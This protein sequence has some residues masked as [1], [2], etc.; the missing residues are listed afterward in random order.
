MKNPAIQSVDYGMIQIQKALKDLR[1][2][3]EAVF[4]EDAIQGL[5]D[6]LEQLAKE[7]KILR[8]SEFRHRNLVGR[9]T[10]LYKDLATVNATVMEPK[11]KR[12]ALKSIQ[13]RIF[14]LVA[15]L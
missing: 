7:R 4:V 2:A 14:E 3:R 10:G 13:T 1:P 11:D 15:K 12:K 8:K 6:R 9:L 5:S